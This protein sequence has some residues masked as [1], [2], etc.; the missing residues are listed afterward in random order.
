[1]PPR[2]QNQVETI[3]D[4]IPCRDFF[5]IAPRARLVFATALTV[6]FIISRGFTMRAFLVLLVLVTAVG[7]SPR[8]SVPLAKLDPFSAKFVTAALDRTKEMVIYDS[9]YEQIAYPGGDVAAW[10]G[11]CSDEVIRVYR[12]LGADLQKLVHEDMKRAFSAYPKTWGLA[13]PDPNIDHRRVPNLATF[14]RRHGTTLPISEVGKDYRPGDVVTWSVGGGRP[15]IGMVTNKLSFD[16]Q[17]P[18]IVHNIGLGPQLDDMLFNYPIT[19]H[20]RYEVAVQ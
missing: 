10:K 14:F 4:L 17:R 3:T 1:M 8:E 13:R 5:L 16:R 6:A 9:A 12:A 20:F 18:L 2:Q 19:G 11:V 7:C 15:H